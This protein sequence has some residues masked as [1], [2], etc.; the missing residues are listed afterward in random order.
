MVELCEGHRKLRH[1]FLFNDVMACAKYKS[2]GRG[3]ITFELKWYVLQ[4]FFFSKI[5]IDGQNLN[6]FCHFRYVH[7]NDLIILE[8]TGNEPKEVSPPN[9]LSLK[10]QVRIFKPF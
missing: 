7:L 10:S 8:E 5:I 2:T 1:L 9:L 6:Y 4:T 3:K